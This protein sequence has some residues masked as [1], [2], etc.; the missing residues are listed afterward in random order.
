MAAQWP[1][2][3]QQCVRDDC[4]P[5]G[6]TPSQSACKADRNFSFVNY[7]FMIKWPGLIC[8]A[9]YYSLIWHKRLCNV[10]DGGPVELCSRCVF[11]EGVKQIGSFLHTEN[12]NSCVHGDALWSPQCS[13]HLRG[14]SGWVSFFTSRR[15]ALLP[16]RCRGHQAYLSCETLAY[17]CAFSLFLHYCFCSMLEMRRTQSL[18]LTLSWVASFSPSLW[19]LRRCM[20]A[21]TMISD[22]WPYFS[23]QRTGPHSLSNQFRN[24]TFAITCN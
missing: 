14:E 9:A 18:L 4:A 17:F 5:S 7:L 22:L 20:R 21:L 16:V 19:V 13:P 12:M 1:R 23:T 8:R 15:A 3:R 10:A 24:I 6:H 2:Q 11:L